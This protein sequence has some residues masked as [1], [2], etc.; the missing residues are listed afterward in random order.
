MGCVHSGHHRG[1]S[2]RSGRPISGEQAALKVLCLVIRT[3]RPN[4][5]NVTGTTTGWKQAINSLAMYYGARIT[6]Q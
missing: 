2:D 6:R 5:A 3:P 4:R 1:G